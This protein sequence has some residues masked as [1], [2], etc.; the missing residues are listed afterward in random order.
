M[1]TYAGAQSEELEGSTPLLLRALFG[2]GGTS[3]RVCLLSTLTLANAGGTTSGRGFE[4]RPC[5]SFDKVAQLVE[6]NRFAD[7]LLPDPK[8]TLAN[9]GWNY[10]HNVEV[11]GSNP[12]PATMA[13]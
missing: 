12:A 3:Y 10:T 1:L 8:L 13:G 7:P 11:A 4:P 5:W 2:M 9:A 6:Q